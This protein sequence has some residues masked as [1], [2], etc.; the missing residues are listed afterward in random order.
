MKLTLTSPSERRPYSERLQQL[1]ALCK[2]ARHTP[3]EL[4][5]RDRRRLALNVALVIPAVHTSGRLSATLQEK[6]V[7]AELCLFLAERCPELERQALKRLPKGSATGRLLARLDQLRAQLADNSTLLTLICDGREAQA[8]AYVKRAHHTRALNALRDEREA[9]AEPPHGAPLIDPLRAPSLTPDERLEQLEGAWRVPGHERA[10]LEVIRDD[11]ALYE[12]GGDLLYIL[13]LPVHLRE[14]FCM[15]Y[16][17]N[18]SAKDIARRLGL[19]VNTVN[20]RTYAAR[21]LIKNLVTGQD[22][23]ER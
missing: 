19:N 17:L 7:R 13:A 11:Q 21:N 9:L 16:I 1:R 12:R 10:L 18:L 20:L 14:A 15:K 2:A 8:Y 3:A 6:L 22:N 4:T 5:A 23:T